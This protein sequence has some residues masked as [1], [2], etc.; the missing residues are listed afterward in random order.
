MVKVLKKASE[1]VSNE[2]EKICM[3]K[4]LI[5]ELI[6]FF[7]C[8]ESAVTFI[9][10]VISLLSQSLLVIFAFPIVSASAVL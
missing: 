10:F 3:Q 2:R 9:D 1:I 5:N 7:E 6:L 8:S 4:N